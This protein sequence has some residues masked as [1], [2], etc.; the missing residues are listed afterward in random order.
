LITRKI[1]L[2]ASCSILF[3]FFFTCF[4]LCTL[5]LYLTLF[6]FL[7]FTALPRLQFTLRSRFFC[8]NF[9][10]LIC[11]SLR[12]DLSLFPFFSS[13]SSFRGSSSLSLFPFLSGCSSSLG[14][15]FTLFGSNIGS[16]RTL[17]SNSHR[18]GSRFWCGTAWGTSEK[19][20]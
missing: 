4:P 12:L 18:S 20:K 8:S 7:C 15:L 5:C 11:N 3:S 10:F 6:F 9:T 2:S 14:C 17:G 16:A 19:T 1:F 13:F